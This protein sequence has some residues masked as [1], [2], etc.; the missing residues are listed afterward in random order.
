MNHQT[1]TLFLHLQHWQGSSTRK[2][3]A[4]IP[5]RLQRP[6]L[7]LA[8]ALAM[9]F[10]QLGAILGG[11]LAIVAA[12]PLSHSIRDVPGRPDAVIRRDIPASH[13]LHERQPLHWTQKWKRDA[14]VPRNALLLM[15]VGLKQRN[16]EEGAELLRDM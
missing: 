14:K 6:S 11:G 13:V 3:L 8:L 10:R 15:R 12:S 1:A 4:D 7:A 9:L 16:L 5:L 2:A